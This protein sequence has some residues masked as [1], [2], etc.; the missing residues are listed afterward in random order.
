M[1]SA[2]APSIFLVLEIG[3]GVFE[4]KATNGD[5]HLGGD[6]WD[7]TLMDWI[8]DEFKKEERHGP[9]QAARRAPTHQGR[10][11]ESQDRAL[12]LLAYDINL[13]FITADASG[14]KHIQKN[15]TRAKMEQ[16][17]TACSSAPSS[18]CK[19]A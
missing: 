15:L 12:Q 16:L 13:P 11:R 14:P 6:D 9:A 7:N 3:D 5:T 19:P 4:V 17:T 1:T 10:S 8:L 18:P 2:A